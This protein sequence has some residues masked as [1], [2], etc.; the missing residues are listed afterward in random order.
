MQ[1]EPVHCFPKLGVA[2]EGVDV[3]SN[4]G[5]DDKSQAGLLW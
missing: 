3:A 4:V 1:W 2:P 5:G